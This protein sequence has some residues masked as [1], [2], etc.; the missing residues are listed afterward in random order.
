[1]GTYQMWIGADSHGIPRIGAVEGANNPDICSVSEKIYPSQMKHRC[2]AISEDGEDYVI[3]T[4]T[5][6]QARGLE[7]TS[8]F[9]QA[10]GSLS[11][12]R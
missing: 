4:P 5:E 1:M 3:V 9:P 7:I 11:C 2:V 12:R 8:W 6:A 10:D